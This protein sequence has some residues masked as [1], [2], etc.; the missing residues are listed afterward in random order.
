MNLKPVRLTETSTRSKIIHVNYFVDE[1]LGV[2]ACTSNAAT[3]DAKFKNVVG[4]IPVGNNNSSIG[5]WIVSPNLAQ[6]E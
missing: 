5:G 6:G 1:E 4:A 3:L 2:A